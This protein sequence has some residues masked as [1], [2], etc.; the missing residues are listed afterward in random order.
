MKIRE[1]RNKEKARKDLFSSESAASTVIAA[2]LLL[3][4]I[5]TIF[6]VVRIAYI[7]E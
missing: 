7:P 1:S 3:S 4:I 6:A 2:V 5:F